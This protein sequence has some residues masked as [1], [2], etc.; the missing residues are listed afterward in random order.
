MVETEKKVQRY[1]SYKESGVEWLGEIPEHWEVLPLF[2]LTKLKSITNNSGLELL[3]VYLDK[4]VIRFADVTAKR[5]NV[6]SLDL[7]KYQLVNLGDF[8]LNNQQAWRGSVGVSNYNGIVSPAYIVLSLS[9]KLNPDFANYLFRD[10]SMVSQYLINSKGVGTIQRN[11][12]WPSLRRS[13]ISLPKLEEQTAIAQFLDDKTTKIDEAITIKQQQISL[14]KE[15]KQILIHKAVTR[16]LNPNVKLKNS[17]VEWIGEIPEHWEV[18]RVKHLLDERTERSEDGKEPLLMMS[19]IH[20]LVV[21]SDFHSKAEVAQNSEG[22]KIVKTN[23]LV[24]NKLKAH[25]GV[26]FKSNIEFDGI[27]SPDYAVYYSKGIFSDLKFLE[28]LFRNPEY[29]KEFICRATGI[30]EGLIRLYT[31]DLFDIHVA[32]PPKNE[33][34]KIL[35]YIETASQK[36]ET[37]ISL[38]QQEIA[39]LKEY[40]SSLINSVVTGKVKVC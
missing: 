35:E 32:V 21:R 15:R 30:V 19:Q 12:Y 14:L 22:N 13:S 28:L 8:V 2:A 5:T 7:S 37:A 38:K 1:E 36:I 34:K 18:K 31:S 25:L 27:V 9:E 17:G 16:G 11:L 40:K 20:G 10:S 29:I 24:F 4:G 23:D 33:Q 39:K 6:T 26:F 3:S